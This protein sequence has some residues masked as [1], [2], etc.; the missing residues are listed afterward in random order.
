MCEDAAL[1]KALAPYAGPKG[2]LRFPLD[3]PFPYALL[4]RI[5]KLRVKQ[6]QARAAKR[7]A[8]KKR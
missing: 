3:E 5:V 6:E 1:V 4:T 8:K 7:P 2:N